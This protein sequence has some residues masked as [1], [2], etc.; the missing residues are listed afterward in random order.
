MS[1]IAGE[2]SALSTASVIDFYRRFVRPEGTDAHYLLV[3]KMATVFWGA[4]AS[5]VAVWAVELAATSGATTSG[6]PTR[7]RPSS[8]RPANS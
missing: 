1:T 2:L 8:T 7:V 6:F 5:V 3:S 4:F